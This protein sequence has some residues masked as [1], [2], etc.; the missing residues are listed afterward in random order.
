M[1]SNFWEANYI[2]DNTPEIFVDVGAKTGYVGQH[3]S[4]AGSFTHFFEPDERYSQ[5]IQSILDDPDV[6]GKHSDMAVSNFNGETTLCKT[7]KGLRMFGSEETQSVKCKSL[8]CMFDT[9]IFDGVSIAVRINVGGQ[10]FH[11]LEGMYSMMDIT[12]YIIIHMHPSMSGFI[13]DCRDIL[14]SEGYSV[15]DSHGDIFVYSI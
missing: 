10:E 5:M 4:Y 6:N 11:V 12:D 3:A 15:S 14:T 13:D 2:R 8:D 7:E 1:N 9:D